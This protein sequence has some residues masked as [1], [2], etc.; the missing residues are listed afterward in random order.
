M[1]AIENEPGQPADLAETGG[2]PLE[3]AEQM[4]WSR[5]L[6]DQIA[7]Y[8]GEF[9]ALADGRIVGHNADLLA[10]MADVRR[11]GIQRPYIVS[12]PSADALVL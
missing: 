10:L 11:L 9:V 3:H 8:R 1:K 7:Q 6:A 2:E 5:A 4:A 12:V